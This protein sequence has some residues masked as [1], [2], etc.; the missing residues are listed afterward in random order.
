[1]RDQGLNWS[2]KENV[3]I[4][5]IVY[6][7]GPM[8]WTVCIEVTLIDSAI[9]K[10]LEITVDN[11]QCSSWSRYWQSFISLVTYVCANDLWCDEKVT[12]ITA[13]VCFCHHTWGPRGGAAAEMWPRQTIQVRRCLHSDGWTLLL[14]QRHSNQVQCRLLLHSSR[15]HMHV[16]YSRI[17]YCLWPGVQQ[18]PASTEIRSMSWIMSWGWS[19]QQCSWYG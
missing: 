9:I 10:K 12:D 15:G 11:L 2:L 5:F 7:S 3:I 8:T 19:L 4:K 13:I 6:L 17:R 16:Q 18:R 1:M 14:R